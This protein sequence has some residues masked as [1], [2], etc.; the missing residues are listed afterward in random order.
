[1]AIAIVYMAKEF[2]WNHIAQGYV[3][4]SFYIGY[5]TTQVIAGV[6]ADK[7]GGR[8]ILGIAAATCALFTSFSARI[9]MYCLILCRICLGIGE[10]V[11]LPCISSIITKWFPLKND[12]EQFDNICFYF[13]WFVDR[14]A[15]I[16]YIGF[17]PIWL[18]KHFLGICNCYLYL[19]CYLVFLWEKLS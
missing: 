18:G 4:S 10:G 19:D 7:F 16:K 17:E 12:L 5:P 15:N 1:M 8:R 6:L 14:N 11:T 9:N 3:L 2:N 13:Y